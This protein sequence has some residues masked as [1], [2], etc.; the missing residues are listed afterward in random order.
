LRADVES[1]LDLAIT[2]RIRETLARLEPHALFDS[3]D[4]IADRLQRDPELRAAV[5]QRL[6][7]DDTSRFDSETTEE[8]LVLTVEP[9]A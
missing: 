1:R 3:P 6:S 7:A 2:A 9:D 8:H 4:E 5:L